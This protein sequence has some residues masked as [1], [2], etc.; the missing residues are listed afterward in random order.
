VVGRLATLQAGAL[1]G[2]LRKRVG[3]AGL[4]KLLGGDPF[5]SKVLDGSG[6]FSI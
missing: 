6:T 4:F 3:A 5:A 2:E 1:S